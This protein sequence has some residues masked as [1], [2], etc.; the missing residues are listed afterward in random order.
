M[1]HRLSARLFYALYIRER[2]LVRVIAIFLLAT[3]LSACVSVSFRGLVSL[4]GTA[5]SAGVTSEAAA[6]AVAGSRVGAVAFNRALIVGGRQGTTAIRVM[7]N[8]R[9]VLE[10]SLSQ[11]GAVS[12]LR[13]RFG[14]VILSSRISAQQVIHSGRS[15]VVSYSRISGNGSRVEHFDVVAGREISVG[16]DL[17]QSNTRIAHY[18]SRGVLIGNTELISIRSGDLPRFLGPIVT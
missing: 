10:G 4:R 15:G 1:T 3:S 17:V 11:E 6:L 8:G 7:S 5:A 13:D 12:V 18:N 2:A 9:V 14:N 16:H